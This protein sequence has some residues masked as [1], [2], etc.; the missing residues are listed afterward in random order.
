M[1]KIQPHGNASNDKQYLQRENEIMTD[2]QK[3]QLE[4]T[5]KADGK[6]TDKIIK[7]LSDNIIDFRGAE[8]YI[9]DT[10]QKEKIGE[11]ETDTVFSFLRSKT[12]QQTL[13]TFKKRGFIKSWADYEKF[14]REFDPSKEFT[15]STFNRTFPRGTISYIGAR[16]SVG[17]TTFLTC[18]SIDAIL[19]GRTVKFVSSE[20]TTEQILN[21]IIRNV[22]Y[23]SML[24]PD[25]K[26]KSQ[27][28]KIYDW[29]TT[30]GNT[31]RSNLRKYMKAAAADLPNIHAAENADIFESAVNTV[32]TWI[33]SGKLEIM[34]TTSANWADVMDFINTADEGEI[35]LVDY[36]QHLPT[37]DKTSFSRQLQLQDMSKA[38]ADAAAKTKAAIICG[39]QFVR[40]EK[41]QI[42]SEYD[43]LANENFRE[44][45]DL[46]QDAH[47]TIGIGRD[48][49][50]NNVTRYYTCMKDRENGDDKGVYYRLDIQLAWNW[51]KPERDENGNLAE[52]ERPKRR[53][54]K[55]DNTQETEQKEKN[56]GGKRDPKTGRKIA[57]PNSTDDI[58]GR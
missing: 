44:S 9:K 27:Y 42:K 40:P 4:K 35:V 38:I 2:Q 10:L 48:R 23:T 17:K 56:N 20:E 46:E 54:E 50:A 22:A 31:P 16:P 37:P 30:A 11:Q 8:Q 28:I 55:Q 26:I 7:T 45:G 47:I 34:E 53:G 43:F 14:N 13:E 19:Q 58:L 6:D 24:G 15:S 29:N 33:T 25:Q 39:A 5:L 21:R 36:I 18:M 1:R 52:W 32:K 51:I 49:R 41:E 3:E 57:D 12:K